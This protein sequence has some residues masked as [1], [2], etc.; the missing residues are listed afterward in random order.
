MFWVVPL[1]GAVLILATFG[2]GYRLVSPHLGA[3]AAFILATSPTFIDSQLR[4]MT[5]M[6]V[7]AAWTAAVWCV[8]GTTV[9]SALGAGVALAI[10][11]LIRPNLAPLGVV[12]ALWVGVRVWQASANRRREVVRGLI[13]LGGLGAGVVATTTM[14][15][16]MYA[17]PFESGY[18]PAGQYFDV[19]YIPPNVITYAKLFWFDMTAIGYL[20][21]GVLIV[22]FARF[23][24]GLK[25]RTAI[26]MCA[27]L[28]LVVWAQ[29][30][31]FLP[32]SAALRFL[33]PCFPFIAIGFAS[34]ALSFATSLRRSVA[35]AAVVVVCGVLNASSAVRAGTFDQWQMVY[36]AHIGDAIA[37]RT[38]QN[39]VVLAMQHSGSIRYYGG[40][41]TLRWDVLDKDWLDRAVGWMADRGV[42]AYALLEHWELPLVKER[43]ANQKLAAVFDQPPA[44]TMGDIAFFDLGAAADPARK[45]AVLPWNPQRGYAPAPAP[46]PT[47]VWKPR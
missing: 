40:R 15:W 13:I 18:G 39:S 6:P 7:T 27:L 47:L 14:Y 25:D 2:I 26:L 36:Y 10:A 20:G 5:E 1:A 3:A 19:A 4:M 17:S 35:A 11:I 38:P 42:P 33:L 24:P 31:A 44:F 43:F 23:W 45:T 28:V 37:Q 46:L 30:C 34:L 29:F 8:L 12:I 9:R 16:L 32:G 21:L 22:P 41:V